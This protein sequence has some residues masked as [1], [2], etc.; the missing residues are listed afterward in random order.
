VFLPVYVV[1][2]KSLMRS[3]K[4]ERRRDKERTRKVVEQRYGSRNVFVDNN[5]LG[6]GN[7]FLSYLKDNIPFP[8]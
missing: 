7:I 3:T 2:M 8:F 1:L 5:D 6:A 4:R